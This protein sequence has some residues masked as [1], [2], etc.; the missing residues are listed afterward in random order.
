MKLA[1][2]IGVVT[3][4]LALAGCATAPRPGAM[5]SACAL[6][7]ASPACQVQRYHDVSAP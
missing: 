7:E 5:V 2:R 3:L 1:G 4:L 6:G